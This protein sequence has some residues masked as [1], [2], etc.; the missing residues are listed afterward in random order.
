MTRRHGVTGMLTP[1]PMRTS[2]PFANCIWSS[3]MVSSPGEG[4]A[5]MFGP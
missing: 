1:S 2:R 3:S 5:M 4:S